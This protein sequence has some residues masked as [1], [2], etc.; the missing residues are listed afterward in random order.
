M[1]HN[2]TSKDRDGRTIIA[3]VSGLVAIPAVVI[4]GFLLTVSSCNPPSATEDGSRSVATV[5]TT[6][7]APAPARVD[8]QS[9]AAVGDP[10]PWADYWSDAPA[11]EVTVM[12][13]NIT[14]PA[15]ETASISSCRLQAVTDGSEI[16][17][18]VSW[19]DP[20]PNQATDSGLFGD[21]VALQFPVKPNSNVMMG[22]GGGKVQLL[23]WKAIWQRDL[24]HGFQ[25]VVDRHPNFW[26]DLYWFSD[27]PWPYP[28]ETA[29][30]DPR[31]QQWMVAYRAGNPFSDWQRP[32]PVEE[33][34]AE[35]FGTLTTQAS[36]ITSGRGAWSWDSWA[37][38][39]TR[40]LR[41]EDPDDFQFG[42]D[43]DH[44][45]AV[46]LWQGSAGNVGG[47]KHWSNWVPFTLPED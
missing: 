24:D 31:S 16:A 8:V 25:D 34:V 39:F 3:F 7:P 5:T 17:W 10:D 35:G 18:R 1:S 29:F 13:Q 43:S 42:P 30:T 21:A 36:S 33:S 47:R 41:S 15:L 2:E 19:R 28:L 40:P 37:V 27:Q 9:V 44:Q 20:Q 23:H 14:M 6:A 22:L 38:V 46:A 11:C 32:Q 26:S 4:G 12:P 45:V